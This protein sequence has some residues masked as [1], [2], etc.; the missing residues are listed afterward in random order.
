[1]RIGFDISQTGSN[2]AGC[3]YL[4]YNLIRALVEIDQENT[5]LQYP[6]FGDFFFDPDWKKS[7]SVVKQKNFSKGF[8]NKTLKDVKEFWNNPPSD[9]EELLGNPDIIQSNNFYCPVGVK[10]AKLVYVLYD[11]G[12]VEY[13]DATTEANRIGCFNGVFRASVFADHIISI[14]EYSKQYF[15][16]IFPHYP[17]EKISV[18]PLASRF[19]SD[20]NEPLSQPASLKGLV[21]DKFWFNLGTLEPRKNQIGLLE[22]YAKLKKM[23]ENEYPLVIGGG[24]GWLLDHFGD[25][26]KKL[27][28]EDDVIMLGYVDEKSLQWL[29]RNCFAF[30]FPSLFEGFGLPVL[31]AMS[32]GAAVITSNVTSIPEVVG[33]AGIMVNPKDTDALSEAMY[34]LS[35]KK[36][37]YHSLKKKALDRTRFFSWENSANKILDIYAK[38]LTI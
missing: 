7:I 27:G 8:A 29:Y 30:V 11:M 23:G 13:P 26:I 4:A 38:V 5:Y 33:D 15:L 20:V 16:N 1:M 37:D 10:K 35:P 31:E 21:E 36:N 12:F 9:F 32:Q 34:D 6:T 14:S 24:K 28:L 3:G 2:K 25:V 18:V 19:F 22:A 17:D